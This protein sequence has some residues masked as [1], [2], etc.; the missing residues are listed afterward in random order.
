M[1]NSIHQMLSPAWRWSTLLVIIVVGVTIRL[2]FWQLDRQKQRNDFI[3]HVNSV[4]NL[5]E[6]DLSGDIA[7]IDLVSN[8][9]RNIKATGRFDFENQ[10]ALRNQVWVQTWGNDLGY[11]LF[12][13]FKLINGLVVLVQRGWIPIDHNTSASWRE[14]E[15]EGEMTILG[16]IRIPIEAGEMG[17]GVPDPTYSPGEKMNYLWNY[18][19]IE[20]LQNFMPYDLLPIYIQQAPDSGNE[21]YPYASRPELDLS[22]GAHLGYALQWFMYS[23]LIL[24]GYPI[25]INRRDNELDDNNND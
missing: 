1:K 4:I 21:S 23:L 8:E 20:R 15:V 9:Y 6:L 2:G 14:F 11:S 5:P 17:G 13:P 19:D 18:I 12:T 10:V 3:N 7:N 25:L 16:V 22:E 24:I